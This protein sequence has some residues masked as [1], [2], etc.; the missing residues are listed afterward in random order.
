MA[1]ITRRGDNKWRV[2]VRRNGLPP[3]YKTFETHADARRW[4]ERLEGRIASDDFVD[5][6]EAK[7]T[8]L[9]EALERYL[10][11]VTP[12]KKGAKQETNRIKAWLRDSLADRPL[13]SIRS[14]DISA[15]RNERTQAGKAPTTIKNALTIIS[16]VYQLAATEWGMEGLRNPVRGVKMP[17]GRPARER[18]LEPG[19]EERLLKACAASGNIWL[20]PVAMWAIETAMRQGEILGL[21]RRYIRGSV[22][23][24]P[25]TKTDRPRSVPLSSRALSIL[26]DVPTAIGGVVFPITQDSLE[27]YWRKA[28]GAAGIEDLHFHDLRHEATSRLFERGLDAMEVMAITGHS[29]TEML[30]RYTHFRAANLALKLG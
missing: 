17:R 4:A 24:L 29:T 20:Q 18:R 3:Q 28:C 2:Q 23:Y 16:Q 5:L 15:W 7:R 27:Y 25:D 6:T 11:E 26:Q 30:R 1:S 12:G 13:A 21:A 19:E 8:T 22:A 10:A 14:M 9:G